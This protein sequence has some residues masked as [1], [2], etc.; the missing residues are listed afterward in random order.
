[1][2]SNSLQ[3]LYAIIDLPSLGG[4]PP[5]T[6]AKDYLAGGIRI[7]QLRDKRRLESPESRQ[8]FLEAA[9]GLKELRKEAD[10]LFI[11]NDDLE[12]ARET[13]SDGIHV[14]RDD[15]AI[16]DCRK[17][18]GDGR[19]VGFSS[20]SLEEAIEAERQ[21]A[22]Y[23][24][25]GA[26]FPTK[27][28]GPGHPIQGLE[29]LREVVRA[30]RIPVVAIGG[31]GESN[32]REVLGTGASMAAMISGLSGASDRVRTAHSLCRISNERVMLPW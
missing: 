31:I 16:S 12:I 23:V 7:I 24:A 18:L 21:G 27:N 11:V 26:I 8:R 5:W 20:H 6:V 4:L 10:F 32:L 25:F 13:G 9:R 2:R 17:R 19:M 29:K 1:M 3:G 28:K 14:G 30:V 22:D 15:P